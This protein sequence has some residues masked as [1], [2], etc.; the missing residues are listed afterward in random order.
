MSLSLLASSCGGG[1]GTSSPVQPPAPPPVS[2]SINPG[3]ASVVLG[4]TQQFSATVGGASNTAVTWAVNGIP[5]G[6]ASVGAI[7]PAGLFTAPQ[8]LPT[9]ASVTVTATSA[10]D[11]TKTASAT[12]AIQSD[13]AITISPDPASVELGAR[14]T[15]A[16]TIASAG[17]PN[18]AVSWTVNAI[19][20][21]NAT[22]G[23]ITVNGD[24]TAPPNL[25]SPATVTIA[26]TSQADTSKSDAA[27]VSVTSTF[28][29]VISGPATVNTGATAA[30]SASIVPAPG[31][32][33]NPATTWSINGVPNGNAAL[34][35]ICLSGIANCIAPASPV[36]GAI[37][38]R[39]PLVAPASPNVMLTAAS[40]ADP[41]KTAATMVAIQSIVAVTVSPSSGV[42]VALG[43]SLTFTATVSGATDQRVQWDVNGVIGGDQ[44]TTGAIN[45]PAS[46]IGPAPYFAPSQLPGA[47]N[48]VTIRA[49][50]QFDPSKSASV[51]VQLFSNVAL[52]AYTMSGANASLRAINRK[53]TLCVALTNATN[54][55]VLWTVNQIPDGNAAFGTIVAA[56]GPGCPAQ[57][58]PGSAITKYE[59]TAP[60]IVPIPSEVTATVTSVAD[61][62]R[63]DSVTITILPAP[64]VTVSPSSLTLLPNARAQLS[65]TVAGTPVAGVAWDVNGIANGDATVGL[66]CVVLS[67]SCTAPVSP[68]IAAVEYR[69]PT[70]VP[71]VPL[72]TITATGADGG[73]A[74][75]T[76]TITSAPPVTTP[77]ITGLLPASVTAG[78]AGPFL[79]KVTGA[80][81]VA[82]SGSSA[83]VIL[84]GNPPLAKTTSCLTPAAN[85]HECTAT[86]DAA[87]VAAANSLSVRIRNPDN[88]LSDLVTFVVDAE[89]AN[90]DS[91]SLTPAA[92]NATGKDI[93]VVEPL[94]AGSGAQ[95]LEIS[96]VSTLANN[97]CSAQ[98][99]PIAIQRPASGSITVDLCL[100]GT[101]LTTANTYSLS[102]PPDITVGPPQF[103]A[104]GF[105]Q[106]RLPLIIPSTAQPSARTLFTANANKEKSAAT[107]AIEIK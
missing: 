10:A 90:E 58:P 98:A 105:V 26:A 33:P 17:N 46:L 81:F 69:A 72:V 106:I 34:G 25:P 96:F 56:A 88:S 95:T 13:I 97:A 18:R 89:S 65:A 42:T 50:S 60:S 83:S 99:S 86:V 5:G 59:Y 37:E 57:G 32:N 68:A 14:R 43:D 7:T 74:A 84:F 45:N 30:F 87:E 63:S 4:A 76:I 12:A 93:V 101:G 91:I 19:P 100:G 66:I 77:Q 28:A 92:P 107:G 3:N 94:T 52:T 102:G 55:A 1:G 48:T 24:Y 53:E 11:A 62:S 70:A 61:A 85:A 67:D 82:G 71:A 103:I 51:S 49:T 78:V 31:S 27:S 44:N 16:A 35:Q 40:A 2:V 29:I 8:N 39:A 64:I 9:P 54:P 47:A 22:V 73:S 75:A 20:G 15:F 36:N 38:Y 104:L 41:S 6:N 21:G 79:L 80:N 23:A